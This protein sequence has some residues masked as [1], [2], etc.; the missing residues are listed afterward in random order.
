MIKYCKTCASKSK[1]QDGRSACARFKILINPDEDF[2]SKHVTQ[3]QTDVCDLCNIHLP[4]N[5]FCIWINPE[6]TNNYLICKNCYSKIYSCIT[7]KYGNICGFSNDHSE[8]QMVMKTIRQGMM[9]MQTQVKNPNLVIKHC[10]K[11]HCSDG[12]DPH[13]KDVTCFKEQDIGVCPKWEMR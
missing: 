9:T 11:C 6:G 12:A 3:G 4:M 13:I 2:C 7:C 10:Q 8:P 5:Q 1:T